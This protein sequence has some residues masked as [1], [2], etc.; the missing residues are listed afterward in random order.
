MDGAELCWSSGAGE[1]LTG[2]RAP[3]SVRR[4][5]LDELLHEAPVLVDQGD[6]PHAE[7]TRPRRVTAGVLED[8]AAS[9]AHLAVLL[10]EAE[11]DVHQRAQRQRLRAGEEE[12]VGLEVRQ[13]VVG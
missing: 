12:P 1:A 5:L 13:R 11:D 4:G 7:T 6:E 3:R 8:D 9:R 2:A 10:V